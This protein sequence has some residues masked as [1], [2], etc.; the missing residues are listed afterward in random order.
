MSPEE[1]RFNNCLV[2]SLR[3]LG[4]AVVVS[5]F[6][7]A[8]TKRYP[9]AAVDVLG[10]EELRGITGEL[11]AFREYISVE[12]PVF[13]H[14]RKNLQSMLAAARTIARLRRRKYDCCINLV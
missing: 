2:L 7:N 6:I 10:R 5:G 12:I 8:L 11:C 9:H 3:H 13:G 14:H 1:A 4:D